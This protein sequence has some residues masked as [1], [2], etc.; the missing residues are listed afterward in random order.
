MF[1]NPLQQRLSNSKRVLVAGAGG[2]FDIYC[3]VPLSL[4]LAEQGVEVHLANLSFTRLGYAVS[5]EPVKVTADTEGPSEYFPEKWLAQ[6]FRSRGMQQP[7]YAFHRTGVRPLVEAYRQLVEELKLDAI[8]LVDGGTDSLMRGDEVGLGTPEEDL[9]SLAA[10]D[11]QD[12][13]TKLLV[14]V[15]FGVDVFHGVCHAQFLEA[16]AALTETGGCLGSF[17][18]NKESSHTSAYLEAVEFACRQNPIVA[19][20]VNTSIASAIEG[21]FGDYHRSHRT[22]GSKLWINPLMSLCWCFD[23]PAVVRR[24]LILPHVMDTVTYTDMSLAIETAR[25]RIEA[26]K[27]WDEIPL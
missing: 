3:G 16:V 4:A 17:S 14:C 25:D 13:A 26:I 8:V 6:W 12:V 19:S 5:P 18:L 10:V 7:V 22:S 2:G 9:A 21:K 24:S 27:K 1:T 11:A 23:L 20:I 15:G